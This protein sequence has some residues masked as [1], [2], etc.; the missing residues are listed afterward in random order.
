MRTSRQAFVVRLIA[1]LDQKI[2]EEKARRMLPLSDLE[3]SRLKVHL[4]RL[5]EVRSK[6]ESR[7]TSLS[8]ES[9]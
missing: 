2:A 1:E 8:R 5:R 4:A 6:M 3:A 7:L 9:C